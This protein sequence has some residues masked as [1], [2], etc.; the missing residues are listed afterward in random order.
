M[1]YKSILNLGSLFLFTQC[2]TLVEYVPERT[3]Y[4]VTDFD[5]HN[6]DGFFIT[7]EPPKGAYQPVGLVQVEISPKAALTRTGR[8]FDE[9]GFRLYNEFWLIDTYGTQIALDS[10]VEMSKILGADALTNYESSV[11]VTHPVRNQFN[12]PAIPV[13]SV[14]GFAI[15]RDTL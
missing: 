6:Q 9:D 7:T 2:A 14:S 8:G 12:N 5:K 1:K 4:Y 15:K 10:L 13:V 3:D 11:K